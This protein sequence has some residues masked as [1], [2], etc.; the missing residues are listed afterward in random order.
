[1]R[2]T[3]LLLSTQNTVPCASATTPKGLLKAAL[4]PVASTL[5]RAPVPAM[6]LTSPDAVT[7]RTRFPLKS[8]TIM[9]SVAGSTAKPAGSWKRAAEPWPSTPPVAPVG[10]P[11]S[12]LT[13]Q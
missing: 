5:A 2:T 9:V 1:L 10:L 13:F 3:W 6:V 4:V 11:A 8:P 12:V 7:R